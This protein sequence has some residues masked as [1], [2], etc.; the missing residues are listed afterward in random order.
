MPLN[1]NVSAAAASTNSPAAG[2][3]AITTA[4]ANNVAYDTRGSTMYQNQSSRSGVYPVCHRACRIT[5]RTYAM[6]ATP[7]IPK[8]HA[9]L[10]EACHG[11]LVIPETSRTAQ[12]CTIV[13]V[14]N[15]RISSMLRVPSA[16]AISAI[17]TNCN[18]VKAPA[19]EPTIT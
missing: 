15:A 9:A 10:D 19:D 2:C 5:F 16:S 18:P 6:P 17:T 12:K 8:H 4:A 14:P 1:S 11:A 7:Q 3:Q 13:G